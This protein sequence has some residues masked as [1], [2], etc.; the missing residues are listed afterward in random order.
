M[1]D[2]HVV[3][4]SATHHGASCAADPPLIRKKAP[5]DHGSGCCG[6]HHHHPRTNHERSSLLGSILPILA[7]ALCPTCIG[8]WA[9]V[10]S[11]AGLGIVITEAQHHVLLV[12]AIVVALATSG[13]RFV[14]TRVLGPFGLTIVGCACLAASHFFAEENHLLSWLSIAVILGASLWQRRVDRTA[15]SVDH[16]SSPGSAFD[17]PSGDAA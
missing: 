8:V 4:D 13:Y 10:L 9:Q 11:F 7:C 17:Q 2:H 6:G 1:K 3:H 14:R 16:S 5:H 12:I 15:P